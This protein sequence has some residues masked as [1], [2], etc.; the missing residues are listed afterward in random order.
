[1]GRM[2]IM[3]PVNES[4]EQNRD[5][6]PSVSEDQKEEGE[7]FLQFGPWYDKIPFLPKLETN[8]KQED[9]P[10]RGKKKKK[11]GKKKQKESEKEEAPAPMEA[12]ELQMAQLVEKLNR[13]KAVYEEQAAAHFKSRMCLVFLSL[14]QLQEQRS[15][16]RSFEDS[17]CLDLPDRAK[18][19]K[20]Q[21]AVHSAQVRHRCRQ[22][23]C[24][25]DAHPRGALVLPESTSAPAP[26]LSPAFE[27]LWCLLSS[28]HLRSR[29]LFLPINPPVTQHLET[30]LGLAQK[31][32]RRENTIACETLKDLFITNLLPSN[33]KLKCASLLSSFYF[34]CLIRKGFYAHVLV[35]VLQRS[36]VG[37][38]CCDRHSPDA[39]V[40]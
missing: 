18:E 30:L 24:N 32:G 39:L 40:F 20:P 23:G 1:M 31:K 5:L 26:P 38:S 33:R 17:Y 15:M 28:N 9:S 12:V 11:M 2:K 6:N 36:A 19:R 29:S 16:D 3:E 27:L 13:A 22:D 21:V 7:D 14:L 8:I 4:K 34:S 25:N 35:Q 37:T 10:K